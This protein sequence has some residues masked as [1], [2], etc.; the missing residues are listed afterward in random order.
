MTIATTHNRDYPSCFRSSIF[1]ITISS[2][3][4]I[5]SPSFSRTKGIRPVIDSIRTPSLST[6]I[7]THVLAVAERIAPYATAPRASITPAADVEDAGTAAVY[8]DIARGIEK[9][10]WGL[11]AYLLG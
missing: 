7:T 4:G 8:T 10:L 2:I 3:L 11:E 9:W 5:V 1:C 6:T